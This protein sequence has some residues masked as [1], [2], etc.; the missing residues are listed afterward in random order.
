MVKKNDAEITATVTRSKKAKQD[1]LPGVTISDRKIQ[2]IEDLGDALLELEDEASAIRENI[3]DTNENLVAEMR[4]R[5]RTYYSRVTWGSVILKET[6]VSAK[7]KKATGTTGS[8]GDPEE[9]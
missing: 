8:G 6:T 7:V 1:E 5:D 3:K 9:D 2:A 4:R